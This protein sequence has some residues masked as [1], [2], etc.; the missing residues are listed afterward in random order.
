MDIRD[1]LPPSLKHVMAY[2]S[3]AER[4]KRQQAAR[5]AFGHPTPVPPGSEPG[6]AAEP[7][8]AD[9]PTLKVQAASPWSAGAT[10]GVDK[11]ALPSARVPPAAGGAVPERVRV[12]PLRVVVRA[13]L[14][15][16]VVS[17]VV[18][19]WKWRAHEPHAVST[20]PTATHSAVVMASATE[21]VMGVAPAASTN[22][23]AAPSVTATT[24][25]AVPQGATLAPERQR[26]KRKPSNDTD[27]PY[28]D[29]AV[30]PLPAVTALTA[31]TPVAPSPAAATSSK[32]MAP[33][34]EY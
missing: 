15:A 4:E 13:T 14:A 5:D 9:E 10:G 22:V 30:K 31:P 8:D 12:I 19:A 1:Y 7:D 33:T 24:T 16:V 20:S 18:A 6:P 21:L 11:Q 32:V 3:Q 17:A 27:D 28:G 25:A 26:A 23:S 34:P 2:T 29:A